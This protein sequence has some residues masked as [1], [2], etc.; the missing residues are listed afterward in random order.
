MYL[1]CFNVQHSIKLRY[2]VNYGTTNK[3]K[4][5]VLISYLARS[6]EKKFVP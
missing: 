2:V 4:D 5:S 6:S 1:P 3:Q